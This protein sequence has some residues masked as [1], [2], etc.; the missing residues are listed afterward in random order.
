MAESAWKVVMDED[1]VTIS[2]DRFVLTT[3]GSEPG[4]LDT[5]VSQLQGM[6]RTTYGQYCGLSRATEMVG[7]RWSLLIIRDLLVGPRSEAELLSGLPLINARQLAMRLREL[8]YSGVI[9]TI[10]TADGEARH[11][12]TEYGR[13]IEDVVLALGR[14]GAMA[15]AAPRPEDV[16]TEDSVMTTLMATFQADAARD[17]ELRFELHMSGAVVVHAVVDHGRLDMFRGPATDPDIVIHSGPGLKSLLAGEISAADAIAGGQ[18]VISGPPGL[19]ARFVSLF[20]LPKLPSP[21]GSA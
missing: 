6:T 10:T 17:L 15:L 13:A 12:L 8:T 11:E 2:G 4:Q 21:V 16:L 3:N 1:G 18:V 14:W 7:E 20:Q 5:V 9:R 19:L